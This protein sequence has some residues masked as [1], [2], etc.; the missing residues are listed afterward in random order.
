MLEGSSEAQLIHVE[1]RLSCSF[2]HGDIAAGHKLIYRKAF[3]M[4]S[5][6][7][8]HANVVEG[9]GWCCEVDKQLLKIAYRNVNELAHDPNICCA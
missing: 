8:V 9:S 7:C 4:V 2:N 6:G 5:M 1:I 3:S